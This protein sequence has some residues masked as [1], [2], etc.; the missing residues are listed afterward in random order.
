[1]NTQTKSPRLLHIDWARGLAVSWMIRG[2]VINAFLSPA[3]HQS[4]FYHLWQMAGAYTAPAFLFLAG[5]GTGL[6]YAKI[7]Q[8]EIGFGR[9]L[10]LST[11]RGLEVLGIAYLFRIEEFIQWVPYSKIKDLFKFDILNNIGASLILVG[12][13]FALLKKENLRYWALSIFAVLIAVLSPYI[14]HS[15]AVN[16]LP[17]FIRNFFNSTTE[18]G[19]FPIFPYTVFVPAGAIVGLLIRRYKSDP[20]KVTALHLWLIPS[21]TLL[22]LGGIWAAKILPHPSGWIMFYNSAEYSFIRIGMQVASLAGCYFLCRLFN[23]E[24]FSFIRLLGRHSLMI[25]WVH[26]SLIFGRLT[27]AIQKKLSWPQTIT[28]LIIILALMTGLAWAVENWRK[29][30]KH[31]T[32]FTK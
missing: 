28:A 4:K 15:E 24:S 32:S 25:Y 21:G 23:Q 22:I 18:F 13:V 31:L 2:H 11:R 5:L 7:D 30:M 26:I 16:A 12:L 1:M 19:H 6:S 29:G 17:W 8:M 14:W 9:R 20:Q 10:W 27:P 3:Y